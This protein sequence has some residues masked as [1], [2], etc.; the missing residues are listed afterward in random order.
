MSPGGRT[1]TDPAQGK[2]GPTLEAHNS[3]LLL[4]IQ[5]LLEREAVSSVLES[6]WVAQRIQSPDFWFFLSPRIRLQEHGLEQGAGR[7][8]MQVRFFRLLRGLGDS[9]MARERLWLHVASA[10]GS[11]ESCQEGSLSTELGASSEHLGYACTP[12]VDCMRS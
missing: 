11:P 10:Q 2:V 1:Q 5:F 3:H 8:K 12:T 4:C 7:R 6:P 9:T